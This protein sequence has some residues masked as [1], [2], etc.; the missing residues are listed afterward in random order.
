MAWFDSIVT[1]LEKQWKAHHQARSPRA[2]RC[3][4]G[5]QVFFRNSHCLACGADLGYVPDTCEVHTLYA[6]DTQCSWR[7]EYNPAGPRSYRS[8]ANFH[9]SAG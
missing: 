5:R 2:F 3:D 6:G 1:R 7:L 9:S 4:C 8:C